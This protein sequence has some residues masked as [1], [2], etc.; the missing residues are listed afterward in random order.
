MKET[1]K[2]RGVS[3]KDLGRRDWAKGGKDSV[4]EQGSEVKL[5]RNGGSGEPVGV[6]ERRRTLLLVP[7]R[8]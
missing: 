6:G 3:E 8:K 1:I 7:E 5:K 2:K 4:A